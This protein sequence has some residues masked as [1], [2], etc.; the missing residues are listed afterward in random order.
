[1]QWKIGDQIIHVADEFA[2]ACGTYKLFEED[3][4]G[5]LFTIPIDI[6]E[7]VVWLNDMFTRRMLGEAVE[8]QIARIPSITML[9]ALRAADYLGC[10]T[11]LDPIATC[12][13]S[14]IHGM[15]VIEMCMELGVEYRHFHQTEYALKH[16]LVGEDDVE[17][18]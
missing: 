18:F 4:D 17:P 12:I 6:A 7:H 11:L 9:P 3:L 5:G 10:I 1:M 2:G 15:S 8:V 13:A 14:R 16:W